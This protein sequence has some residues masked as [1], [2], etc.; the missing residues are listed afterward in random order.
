MV[1]L[2]KNSEKRHAP[3][4]RPRDAEQTR[5]KIL[6]AAQ[7]AF[8]QKGYAQV[9]IREIA[10]LAG[11]SSSLIDRYFGSKAKLFEAALLDAMRERSILEGE[12]TDFGK[13]LSKR[14]VDPDLDMQLLAMSVFS[15]ADDEAREIVSRITREHIISKMA[16]WLGPPHAKDRAV[17]I[18]MAATG[19]VIYTKQLP[20][21]LP[22]RYSQQWIAQALQNIVDQSDGSNS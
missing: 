17:Q 12:K 3:L 18:M 22:N 14:L 20:V 1:K 10:A 21:G 7:Q 2:S 16:R 6:S 5:N 19:Y 15:A 11:I 4:S 13:R 8:S 9:G